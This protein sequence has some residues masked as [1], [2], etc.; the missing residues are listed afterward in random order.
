MKPTHQVLNVEV[1]PALGVVEVGWITV[2]PV[3]SN[4]GS[5]LIFE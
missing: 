4:L 1:A 3:P 2:L 5:W